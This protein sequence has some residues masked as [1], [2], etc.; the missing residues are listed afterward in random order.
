M[1]VPKTAQWV[2]ALRTTLGK[3]YEPTT[4]Q[5]IPWFLSGEA[6]LALQGVDI[7][8]ERIEFRAVSPFAAAYFSGFMRYYESAANGAT[9]IYRRGGVT[10]PSEG[11]RSNVHQRI[12]VWT[13]GDQMYWF[14]RW[15]VE[16]QPVQVLHIRGLDTDPVSQMKPGDMQRVHFEGMD[17]AVAPVEVLLA[18][19]VIRG[20][21]QLT[22]RVLQT[23]RSSGYRPEILNRA[24]DLL[25][26]DKASRLMRLLEIRLVA[27]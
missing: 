15:N 18:E 13:A 3:V 7:E 16:G 22:N 21:Q 4:R 26:Y 1:C 20:Q 14:G 17:V 19:T 23:L 24:L 2:D 6:A 27:G 10:P 12:V 11:W 9:I 8:P 25:P 5:P